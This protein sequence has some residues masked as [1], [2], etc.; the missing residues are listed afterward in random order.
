MDVGELLGG[1]F[2]LFVRVLAGAPRPLNV[3]D[4]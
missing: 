1:L 3:N 4:R 2:E